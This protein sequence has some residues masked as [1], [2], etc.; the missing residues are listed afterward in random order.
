MSIKL[1]QRTPTT[2]ATIGKCVV[3]VLPTLLLIRPILHILKIKITRAN[4][5]QTTPQQQQLYASTFLKT[6]IYNAEYTYQY[7]SEEVK[8]TDATVKFAMLHVSWTSPF[9]FSKLQSVPTADYLVQRLAEGT[10]KIKPSFN[11]ECTGA[12]AGKMLGPCIGTNE[13]AEALLNGIRCSYGN[14]KGLDGYN[15]FDS[16]NAECIAVVRFSDE[17]CSAIAA[18]KPNSQVQMTFFF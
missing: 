3:L 4:L 10:R 2:T 9:Q 18:T 14:N 7:S 13:T 6:Q 17:S 12:N 8:I 1:C 15:W 5:D 11:S 16:K